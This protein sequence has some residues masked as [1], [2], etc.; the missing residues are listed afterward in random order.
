MFGKRF[1]LAPRVEGELD[2]WVSV[3]VRLVQPMP[4]ADGAGEEVV[5]YYRNIG[6]RIPGPQ[7]KQ[8]LERLIL[9]GTIEWG[10]T[11]VGEVELSSL[12]RETRKC[13]TAPD[14]DGVW[15]RSGCMYFSEG[16]GANAV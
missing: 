11:D 12:D 2:V 6:I 3:C 16:E 13:V 10:E 15:Y 9:D 5:G 7:P 14:A 4:R 8:F 1:P